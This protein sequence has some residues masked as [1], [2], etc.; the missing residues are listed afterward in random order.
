[1]WSATDNYWSTRT[2]VQSVYSSNDQLSIT[3]FC[4]IVHSHVML[5]A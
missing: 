1:M 3:V 5:D 2:V 4:L